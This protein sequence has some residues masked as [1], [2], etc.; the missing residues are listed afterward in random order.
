MN[1]I[2]FVKDGNKFTD[3]DNNVFNGVLASNGL[4]YVIT[5]TANETTYVVT[6]IDDANDEKDGWYAIDEKTNLIT[7]KKTTM[8]DLQKDPAALLDNVFL[9]DVM[10]LHAGSDP[11]LLSIAY[12]N[13]GEAF[14]IQDNNGNRKDDQADTIVMNPGYSPKT[15]KDLRSNGNLFNE[16]RLATVLN[17]NVNSEPIMIELAYGVE[18][19]DFTGLT[20]E[21]ALEVTVGTDRPVDGD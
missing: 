17:V 4:D 13:K 8:K 14:Y 21:N 9:C 2:T 10:N 3:V 20:L 19:K 7:Y 11:I 1:P 12:G 16:L 5:D 15:I 18:K 6:Y